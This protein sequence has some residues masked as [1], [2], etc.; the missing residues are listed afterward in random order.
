MQMDDR[1]N[2]IRR[3]ALDQADRAKRGAVLWLVVAAVWEGACLIAFLLLLDFSDRLH[4][5]L[6]VM[7]LLI[8]GTLALALVALAAY[9]RSWMLR[10]LKAIELLDSPGSDAPQK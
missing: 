6:L 4:Q 2:G 5:V 1:L 7:A 9:G 8:Y 10:A 3:A